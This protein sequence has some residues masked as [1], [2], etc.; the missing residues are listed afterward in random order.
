[1]AVRRFHPWQ[2]DFRAIAEGV[3]REDK[4]RSQRMIS[5]RMRKYVTVEMPTDRGSQ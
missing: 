2:R 1:M 5:A 4:S 3:E